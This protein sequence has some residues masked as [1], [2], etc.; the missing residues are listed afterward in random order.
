MLPLPE[1]AILQMSI[2]CLPTKNFAFLCLMLLANN[3]LQLPIASA[4]DNPRAKCE[5]NLLEMRKVLVAIT[6]KIA[7]MPPLADIYIDLKQLTDRS[8]SE[9]TNGNYSECIRLTEVGL[10][11][12][13]PYAG[14]L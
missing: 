3:F 6:Y 9:L 11:I 12:G 5:Q 14:P 8:Q 7:G 2:V 10:R 4:Q 1:R 13:K